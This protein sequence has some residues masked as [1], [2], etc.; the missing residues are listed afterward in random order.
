MEGDKLVNMNTS[1]RAYEEDFNVAGFTN[2]YKKP[3]GASVAFQDPIEGNKKRYTWDTFASA[4]RIT[5]EM[6]EDNLYG[7]IGAKWSRFLGRAARYNK[8]IVMHSPYNNAFDTAYTGILA[9]ST[10]ESL[11]DTHALLRGGSIRNRPTTD[12]DFDLL[13]FQAA[14]EHFHSLTD[15][16]GIPAVFIPKIVVHSAQLEWIVNQVLKTPAG[17]Q[18][19]AQD[20]NVAARQGVNPH[21]S[22]F[23]TDADSWYVIC[24]EHDVNY[25]DRRPF[26]F[27][28]SDDWYTG[29]ALFKGTRRNGAG[30]GDWRGIYG[31]AGE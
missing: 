15:E 31:S 1:K 13:T 17:L 2:L 18:T 24:D 4:F 25:F 9:T 22:H 8:E 19:T 12:A 7:L 27:S 14:I 11:C 5:E 28:N 29:D 23:L 20:I 16:S 26:V 3:E 10:A 6:G 30:H 21:L